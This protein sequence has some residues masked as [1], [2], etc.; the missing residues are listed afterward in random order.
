[1]VWYVRAHPNLTFHPSGLPTHIFCR[2]F[3]EPHTGEPKSWSSVDPSPARSRSR[4]KKIHLIFDPASPNSTASCVCVSRCLRVKLVSPPAPGSDAVAPFSFFW[5]MQTRLTVTALPRAGWD[6]CS[7]QKSERDSI[8]ATTPIPYKTW[9]IIVRYFEPYIN[10][11]CH[12]RYSP[13][14]MQGR[15]PC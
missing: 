14:Y 9:N 1:M 11:N 2:P 6:G 12:V 15:V 7:T 4:E 10:A 5:G 13:I 8:T 3:R